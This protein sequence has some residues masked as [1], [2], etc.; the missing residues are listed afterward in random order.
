MSVFQLQRTASFTGVFHSPL[1][2]LFL[3]PQS[4]ERTSDFFWKLCAVRLQFEI[5]FLHFFGDN[6]LWSANVSYFGLCSNNTIKTLS[7]DSLVIWRFMMRRESIAMSLVLLGKFYC[8]WLLRDLVAPKGAV[9]LCWQTVQSNR[10]IRTGYGLVVSERT[11]H[12]WLSQS[13][14]WR[15]RCMSQHHGLR[16]QGKLWER[17]GSPR[18]SGQRFAWH[19][20]GEQDDGWLAWWCLE[21]YHE[22]SFG[23][24][25]RLLFLDLC[26]LYRDQTY[27]LLLV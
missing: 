2:S 26:L 5:S 3:A 12:P 13:F 24:A 16:S 10:Q 18:R 4:L 9:C 8:S 6:N 27:W 1:Q 23:D 20:H 25:W 19:R 15:A 14:S 7:L 17:H 11:P 21:C 22:G